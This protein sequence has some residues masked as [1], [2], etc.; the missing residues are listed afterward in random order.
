M[1]DEP[2]SL[3]QLYQA[4]EQHLTTHLP[5]VQAVT[6]WPNISDRVALPAV[7]LELAEIEPGPDIGTGETTLVCKFEARIIVDPIKLHHQRQ[8]VQLATQLAVLL[9]AQTWGLPVDPAEFVQAQQDWTQPALDGYTV[10]LVEWTQQ[11]YLGAE[12]WPWPEEPPGSLVID[13]APGDGSFN[14]EDLQ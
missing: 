5:G 4:V 11:I 14:P 10:W 12:Q 6:V 7:F 3:D 1:S 2:L 13:I 8:A 9:R